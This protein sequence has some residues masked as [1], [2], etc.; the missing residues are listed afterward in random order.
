MDVRNFVNIKKI[1]GGNRNES[2]IVGGV[3]FSKN[4]A[5]K[6]MKTKIE[7][8]RILLL[9]CAIAYQRVEGKFVTIESL[10]LQVNYALRNSFKC[11]KFYQFSGRRI[12]P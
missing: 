3:V 2:T 7:N 9:Q 12:P 4:V 10:I 5:H 11:S 1:S 6:D 8:P